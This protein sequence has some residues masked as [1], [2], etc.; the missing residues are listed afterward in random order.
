M[1]QASF[2]IWHAIT[3]FY[4]MIMETYLTL[5]NLGRV[6]TDIVYPNGEVTL[7]CTSEPCSITTYDLYNDK[8]FYEAVTSP[9]KS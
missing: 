2:A 8:I 7:V 3:S 4:K 9:M 6:S 5:I 1:S